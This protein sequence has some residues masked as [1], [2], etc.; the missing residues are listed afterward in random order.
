MIHQYSQYRF[1]RFSVLIKHKQNSGV[2]CAT[3]NLI[4]VVHIII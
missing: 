2:G 4:S 1:R 3:N